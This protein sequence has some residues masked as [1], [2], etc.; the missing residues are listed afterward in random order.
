MRK[1]RFCIVLIKI[2]FFTFSCAPAIENASHLPDSGNYLALGFWH[3]I[4]V[5]FSALGRLIGLD[6]GL[7]DAG[8]EMFSYWVGYIIALVLYLRVIF[9]F[10][11][12][13]WHGKRG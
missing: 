3:G 7:Y 9:F 10:L 13:F 4:I 2:T 8:K 5:P 12:I 1:I 6:I 11:N